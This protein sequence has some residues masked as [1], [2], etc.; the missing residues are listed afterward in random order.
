MVSL[1]N[2]SKR[3]YGQLN[4]EYYRLGIVRKDSDATQSACKVFREAVDQDHRCWPA[5]EGLSTLV[6]VFYTVSS[7]YYS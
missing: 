4:A 3:K 5:W 6:D 7:T 2:N 1:N